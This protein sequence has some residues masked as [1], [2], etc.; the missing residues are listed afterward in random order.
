MANK[1]ELIK[2]LRELTGAGMMDCKNALEATDY[3]LDKA[4][5]WLREKGI[6]T[7]AKKQARIAAEGL[8]T[9]LVRDDYTVILE[10]N[11]ET[12]F[13]A[14]GDLFVELLNKIANLIFDNQYRTFEDANR[15]VTP[16]LQEATLKIGEKLSF[17][18]FEVIKAKKENLFAYKHMGG[19]ITSVVVLEKPDQELARGLAMHIAANNPLYIRRTDIPQD[20]VEHETHIQLEAARND[21][22]LKNKPENILK[23]II[24]GKVNKTFSEATLLEQVYLLDGEKKVEQVLKEHGNN[25][26]HFVRYQ[27]GEGIE[28]PNACT[29]AF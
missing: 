20:E 7:A 14:R 21:E 4:R 28:N 9:A 12:D 1:I 11:C 8:T 22:K 3:D 15:D 25:V 24:E 18:R 13:V 29:C 16:L 10:L 2:T 27:V 5:D 26:L 23:K 19:K 6:A 17:R